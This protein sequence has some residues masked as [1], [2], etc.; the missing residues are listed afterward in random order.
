M[1]RFGLSQ[2]EYMVTKLSK[3]GM[4]DVKLVKS[5]WL[6]IIIFLQVCVQVMKKKRVICL[7]YSVLV[8]RLMIAMK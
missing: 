7:M 2:L 5:F 4:N 3:F 6:S 8:E 1:V